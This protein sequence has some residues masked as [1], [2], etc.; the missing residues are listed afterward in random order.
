[1]TYVGIDPGFFGAIA[2][3]IDDSLRIESLPTIA[4]GLGSRRYHRLMLLTLVQ[5]VPKPA[6]VVLE[7][8]QIRPGESGKSTKAS[9]HGFGHIEMA[10]TVAGVSDSDIHIVPP[11]VW[12]GLMHLGFSSFPNPKDRSY[13]ACKRRFPGVSLCRGHSKKPNDGYADAALL[14]LYAKRIYTGEA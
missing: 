9:N 1:M 8:P 7:D 4:F 13:A 14:A 11:K 5:S 12:Q 10:L 6:F 3:L 2:W